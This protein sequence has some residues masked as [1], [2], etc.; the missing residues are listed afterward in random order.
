MKILVAG[1]GQ[2][3]EAT[4][5]ALLA[6]GREVRLLSLEAESAIGRWP[7]GVEAWVADASQGRNLRGAADGCE[8][9]IQTSAIHDTDIDVRGT[10]ELMSEGA[11][12]GSPRFV[13][14]SSIRLARSASDVGREVRQVEAMAR[15]YRGVWCVLRAGLVYGPGEGAIDAI[16]VMA[17][18]LPAIPLPDGGSIELQPLWRDDLGLALARAAVRPEA[19]NRDLHVAGPERVRLDR[20]VDR[21]CAQLGRKPARIAVPSLLA[22]VGAEAA[23]VL[24][25][26]VPARAA[27]LAELDGDQVLPLSLENALTSVLGVEPTMVEEGLARLV[28]LVPDQTPRDRARPLVRRRY[29]V[30]IEGSTRTARELRDLFRREAHQVLDAADAPPARRMIKKGSLLSARVPLRGHVALRIVEVTP[31]RVTALTVDGDP[32]ASIVDIEF[33]DHPGH[34]GVAITV[35]AEGTTMIDRALLRATGGALEDLDWDGALGRFVALSGGRAADGVERHQTTL[36]AEESA[37][38]RERAERLMRTRQRETAPGGR[39]PRSSPARATSRGRAT[40]RRTGH[41]NI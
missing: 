15:T 32:L 40:P 35:D 23:A 18:T 17:R 7:R 5:T 2:V 19:A 16:A 31:S 38:V 14:L 3:A 13:L 29:R 28:G 30:R 9:V 36:D 8:A 12:A 24:G 34:V 33:L 10:R 20:V 25:L 4:V 11:R 39:K 21:L 6:E 27:A 41:T 37:R 1:T 22:A 26:K